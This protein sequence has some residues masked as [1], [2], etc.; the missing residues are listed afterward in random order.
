MPRVFTSHTSKASSVWYP[1]SRGNLQST[2]PQREEV[3]GPPIFGGIWCCDH[4]QQPI[5]PY[6][7]PDRRHYY[8]SEV[9]FSTRRISGLDTEFK[10][11]GFKQ[12]SK[13]KGL[14]QQQQTR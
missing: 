12:Y 3:P 11:E 13:C 5:Q 14:T 2:F 4:R 9:L 1:D 7:S 6:L 10:S 8:L